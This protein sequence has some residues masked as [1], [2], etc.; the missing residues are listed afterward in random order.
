MFLAVIIF[1]LVF[2]HCVS[3]AQGV[4]MLIRYVKGRMP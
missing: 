3:T 2:H 1:V 4:E